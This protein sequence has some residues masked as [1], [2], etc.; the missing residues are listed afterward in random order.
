MHS[1][2]RWTTFCR[3]NRKHKTDTHRYCGVYF[4]YKKLITNYANLLNIICVCCKI[5][6]I[7][8]QMAG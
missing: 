1:R 6:E 7:N 3:K 5:K 8:R 4:L 2:S